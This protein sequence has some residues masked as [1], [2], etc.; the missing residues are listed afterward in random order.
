MISAL[1]Y[2]NFERG[3]MIGFLDLRYHGLVIK[4][5][6]LMS[7]S[8]GLWVALSQHEGEKDGERKWFDIMHL[9]SPE[10]EHVRRMVVADLAAQG[11]IEPPARST[12]G[13]GGSAQ[14]AQKH[15]VS[16]EGEDL[17]EHYTAGD[18]DIP[19]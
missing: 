5:C 18:D 9:T 10:Q 11:H 1:N 2:K 6:R 14:Q 16:P 17:S 12:S 4:G 8:N 13:R 15:H 19:F 7:G 3:A